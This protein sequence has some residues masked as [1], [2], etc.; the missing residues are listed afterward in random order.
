MVI[1]TPNNRL[2]Q[3]LFIIF[4]F[5]ICVFTEVKFVPVSGDTY[6]IQ[7]MKNL[8]NGLNDITV[9]GDQVVQCSPLDMV[10]DL[11]TPSPSTVI[12]TTQTQ[13]TQV[14]VLVIQ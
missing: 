13:S 7:S 6:R 4:T 5:Y 12:T 8:R 11:V 3:S 9:Y 1:K 2:W 14:N 10:P